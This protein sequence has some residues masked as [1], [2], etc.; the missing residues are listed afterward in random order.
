MN[1]QIEKQ[2]SR[3]LKYGMQLG[4]RRFL[5]TLTFAI[6]IFAITFIYMF[7]LFTNKITDIGKYLFFPVGLF[8][9]IVLILAFI[10]NHYNLDVF[11]DVATKF[12]TIIS[13]SS[14]I[15]IIIY[16]AVPAIY[17]DHKINGVNISMIVIYFL[18]NIVETGYFL[19]SIPRGQ[20]SET[21]GMEKQFAVL[22]KKLEKMDLT[23]LPID[24]AI[25]RGIK[26]LKQRVSKDGVW[27]ELN[28]L[29]DTAAVLEFF[30]S[31][32]Y[33]LNTS[34]FIRTKDGK[35]AVSLKQ[36]Y[37]Y[38]QA[39]TTTFEEIELNYERFYILYTLGLFDPSIFDVYLDT[40]NE[41]KE[42]TK[43][44]TELDFISE[45]NKFTPNVRSRTTPVHL[46]MAYIGDILG[47]IELLD[48]SANLFS[49]TIDIIIKRSFSR[50]S[51]SKT[52][53][54]HMEMFSR[55]MLAL[56]HIRRMPPRRQQFL[57]AVSQTQFIEGSWEDNIGTTSYVI[58]SIIPSENIDS[59]NIKKAALFI[60]AMQDKE[61]LWGGT[62]EDSVLALKA[63]IDIQKFIKEQS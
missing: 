25:N 21:F 59:I 43:Q 32:N 42:S 17:T 51:T 40:I 26:A 56:Y 33:D 50:F 7:V 54:T 49:K 9:E 28:K 47:D 58:R 52:G 24:K 37:D 45:L 27:G 61:G 48:M 8:L 39:V 13:L 62:V 4:F 46:I 5:E 41:Y 38:I 57:K 1:Y 12:F 29:Y 22:E 55:L 60:I 23:S 44:I 3:V 14:L 18:L 10:E 16:S 53:K 6:T 11:G 63:L 2:Y 34:W 15:F 31:L 30:H 36:S 20:I 19:Y 35:V